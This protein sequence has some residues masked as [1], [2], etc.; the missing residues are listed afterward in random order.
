MNDYEEATA[1]ALLVCATVTVGT[2]AELINVDMVNIWSTL[3]KK[4]GIP[5]EFIGLIFIECA[6]RNK[7]FPSLHEA[8]EVWSKIRPSASVIHD[9]VLVVDDQ[10]TIRVGSES[11]CRKNMIKCHHM[12]EL[13][14]LE[15]K[16]H[17]KGLPTLDRSVRIAKE[18]RVDDESPYVDIESRKNQIKEQA[19]VFKK[20]AGLP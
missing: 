12:S 7:F 4:E 18:K 6:K 10:G 3:F 15:G 13:G 9:P 5:K 1:Q 2:N 20:R 16:T 8:F 14:A 17:Q 11:L 19:E